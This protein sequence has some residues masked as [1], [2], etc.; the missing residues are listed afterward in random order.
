MSALVH[1]RYKD[2]RDKIIEMV[3][4]ESF[5]PSLPILTTR[6]IPHYP[7]TNNN[8]IANPMP[9]YENITEVPPIVPIQ[10]FFDKHGTKHF[11]CMNE[12]LDITV[13]DMNEQ[14]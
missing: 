3:N 13:E 12:I 4:K 9:T 1:I 7:P 14:N 6:S 10:C 2:G 11:I 5:A 8:V